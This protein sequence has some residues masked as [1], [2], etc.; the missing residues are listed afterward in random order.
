LDRLF[1][2]IEGIDGATLGHHLFKLK[3]V[4]LNGERIGLREALKRHLLDGIDLFF[5]GIPAFITI[6]NTEKHQ[7]IGDLWAKTFV[8]DLNDPDQQ[9]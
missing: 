4:K 7:R 2:V 8:I 1:V 3:V 5:Y 6:R 9:N